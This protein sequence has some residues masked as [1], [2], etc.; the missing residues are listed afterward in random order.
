MDLG[1]TDRVYVLTGAS[2]GLGFATAQAL[3]AD[4]AKSWAALPA[5]RAPPPTWPTRRPP[6]NWSTWP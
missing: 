4:G 1:L 2:K 5:R 6:P 3:V